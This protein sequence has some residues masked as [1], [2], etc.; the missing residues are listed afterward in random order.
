[1]T[2]LEKMKAKFGEGS[3][4]TINTGK[5]KKK[6]EKVQEV[7]VSQPEPQTKIFNPEEVEINVALCDKKLQWAYPI[8]ALESMKFMAVGNKEHPMP[9]HFSVTVSNGAEVTPH[10]QSA[11]DDGK[12]VWRVWFNQNKPE[13][14]E[15]RGATIDAWSRFFEITELEYL[16]GPSASNLILGIPDKDLIRF[17]EKFEKNLN[18]DRKSA[19]HKKVCGLIKI[20]ANGGGDGMTLWQKADCLSF[21]SKE[22]ND[23]SR[24]HSRF[25]QYVWSGAPQCKIIGTAT[26]MYWK[27]QALRPESSGYWAQNTTENKA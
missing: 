16:P 23:E 24:P 5:P 10:I 25:P 11:F 18:N 21:L 17:V 9:R 8:E 3:V 15:G 12:L 26:Q 20:W 1:M 27:K 14:F 4:E 2:K 13:Y 6:K 19:W 22:T 7:Q